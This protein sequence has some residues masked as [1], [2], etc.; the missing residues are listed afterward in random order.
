MELTMLELTE[1]LTLDLII[2]VVWLPCMQMLKRTGER[3]R[4]GY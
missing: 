3:Q 2:M 1:A 4:D